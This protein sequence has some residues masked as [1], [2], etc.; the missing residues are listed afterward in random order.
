MKKKIVIFLVGLSGGAGQ[1]VLNYFNHMPKDK[2]TV[3]IVTTEIESEKLLK[4]YTD[5]N[6]K[7]Y[8]VTPKR[9]SI[10]K[11]FQENYRL[12]KNNKYDIAYGH[13]TL[14]NF[15]P[16]LISM[17][18][19]IKIRLSHSHLAPNRDKYFFE[20]VL[21][22][23]TKLVSTEF[24]ACGIDAGHFLYGNSD[25]KVLKN[26]I[27]L[28]KYMYL[29]SEN[30]KQRRENGFSENI[31]IIG[32][33]GRF[34]E[35]KNHTFII[36]VFEKYVAKYPDTYLVL[37]GDGFLRNKI[38]SITVKKG[39]REKVYF[40]GQ[41]SDVYRKMMMFDAFILPSLFEGLSL[42]AVEAQAV[43]VNSVFSDKVSKETKLT[44][45]VKF[46]SL[47]SG[48]DNWVDKIHA[49]TV[50]DNNGKENLKKL[51]NEGYDIDLEAKKFDEYL[52]S[53]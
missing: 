31:K 48:L 14:T 21:A 36:E 23:L 34:D 26:A 38:E 9:E 43:G 20:R 2:Y 30:L 27:D 49:A 24:I 15:F 29:D 11:Y 40:L 46:I 6:M 32:H 10:I 53:L 47:N 35:Q 16:L 1:V 19:G 42:A 28:K 18:C 44:N 39:I 41:V 33:V 51:R 8:K 12:I 52:D 45:N 25:F 17:F 5:S 3:D 7:V 13:M 37:I 50:T 4:K 22:F